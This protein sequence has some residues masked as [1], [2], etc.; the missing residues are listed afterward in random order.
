MNIVTPFFQ[1]CTQNP[2]ATAFVEGEQTLTYAEFKSRIEKIA[3]CLQAKQ[4]QNRC[5]AIALDRGINAACAIYGVLSAAAIYLPLD[6]KNPATR[7]QFITQDA[8][9]EYIIGQGKAP[10]WLE[11][12]AIWL[13]IDPLLS[14]Q[15]QHITPLSIE[16]TALAAILYTSGSTGKP[17]GVALS[18]QALL[19]F[20]SW[21][22]KTFA[23]NEQ[24]RIASLAP[25]HFDLSIFDLFPSLANGAS[26]YFLPARLILSPSRL[27]GWLA[28][29][30]ITSWYTVPSL[31]SFIALKGAL[32]TTPLP[33]LKRIL[34]AGEIFPT[35]QLIKLADLL[36][37]VELY[38]LYGPTET[39]VC[40]YWP[41]D[42]QRLSAEG[43]IPIGLP[44]CNAQ[45]SIKSDTGEL[46][47]NSLNNFSGYWQ[48]GKLQPAHSTSYA[49]GDKVSLNRYAE[50]AYHGRL[51][52]MLKCSGYRVEPA[53]IE[54]C[55]NQLDSI[56]N[57]AVV[58]I[59]DSTSGQRPAAV[60][61]L[62]KG[63]TLSAAI[64]PVRQRLPPYMQPCQFIVL[65]SLPVLSNGKI[66][67]QAIQDLFH[68]DKSPK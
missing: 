67:Y 15:A 12:S 57:C 16:P 14:T 13:D 28:E 33:H 7:L 4:V 25:F 30:Q 22:G 19:N 18:H 1:Q 51:D 54:Q 60:V 56:E 20:S 11:N 47:V 44:A 65:D 24:E 52:R 42:R 63:A 5:I 38:N 3:T 17:K 27:T 41:V 53:E 55:I 8:Q 48:Q 61:V 46:Q 58:G 43:T 64:K 9:P 2:Q 40:C 37:K 36:P 6:I 21:A 29:Q 35:Q 49:T 59:K 50:Y 66:D 68:K 34:F 32:G 31:L 23:I 10:E 45:L 26:V 39:N 62:R